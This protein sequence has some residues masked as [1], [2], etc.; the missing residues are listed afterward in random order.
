MKQFFTMIYNFFVKHISLFIL[1]ARFSVYLI[2]VFLSY[3]DNFSGN[4]N[5]RHPY[6]HC[7][8]KGHFGHFD[9]CL[10]T[11]KALSAL[12]QSFGKF[13]S[14]DLRMKF[15]FNWDSLH[16]R[17]NSHYEAWSYK[18]KKHKKIKTYRKFV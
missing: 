3:F 15:F 9:P 7:H 18:K 11:Y 6:S 14:Y 5:G 12:L 16:A 10:K 8:A 13:C 1:R 4:S 17:L 2:D